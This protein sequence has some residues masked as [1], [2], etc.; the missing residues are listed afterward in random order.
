MTK[1]HKKKLIESSMPLDA[2][3]EA[4]G[5][6]NNIHTGLPSNLHTWWSRKPLGIAR[7]AIFA[8]LVDD[9]SEY[10]KSE[11]EEDVERERLFSIIRDLSDVHRGMEPK[12]LAAA[13]AEILRSTDNVLPTFWD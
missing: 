1:P 6:E 8:S 9:P 4:A 5:R 2:I 13:R 3:N 11:E 10:C 12:V 7:A